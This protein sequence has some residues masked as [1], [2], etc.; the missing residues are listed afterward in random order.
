[1]KTRLEKLQLQ[2]TDIVIMTVPAGT[3]RRVFEIRHAA[4][5]KI[6][7]PGQR[8]IVK[9]EGIKIERLADVLTPEE[10]HRLNE[11]M[12]KKI[13]AAPGVGLPLQ[14]PCGRPPASPK[15]K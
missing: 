8:S 13:L 11:Q 14:S 2:P 15:K 6:L 9:A 5:R 10:L 1:M 7:P 12:E 3:S 4:L